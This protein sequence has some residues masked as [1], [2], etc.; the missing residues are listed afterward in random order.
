MLGYPTDTP[1]TPSLWLELIHPLDRVR[2]T[3]ELAAHRTGESPEFTSEYRIQHRNG[4]Y[5]WVLARGLAVRDAVGNAVRMAGSQ[6]DI[7]KGKIADPVTGLPNRLYFLDRVEAT[8][9]AV[10]DNRSACAVLFLDLDRF[11]LINDSL[12][13]SA[14]DELL[15]GVCRRLRSAVG[16][17]EPPAPGTERVVARFGGDEFAILLV[18]PDAE[19]LARVIAERILERLTPAFRVAARQVFASFSIGIAV[20]S[21]GQESAEDL[22]R[23]ADTA[24]YYAKTHGRG[25]F[26]IFDQQMRERAVTRL[27]TESELRKAI[28]GNELQLYYQPQVHLRTGKVVGHEALVR[29]NHPVRGLL[30]PGEFVPIAEESDLIIALGR[31]V[32]REACR[33]TAEWSRRF[34]A[35]PPIRVSVNVSPRQLAVGGFLEDVRF[36]LRQS[37]LDPSQLTLEVTESSIMTNREDVITLLNE[38][39]KLGIG[40][41]IDDFG[42]GYSSLSYLQHLPF[43]TVKIDR[44]F[45]RNLATRADSA[46]IVHA[47]LALAKSL[48]MA[49]VAEGVE[50]AEQLEKLDQ[51]ECGYAQGFYFARPLPAD[52]AESCIR[53]AANSGRSGFDRLLDQP[54]S[55]ADSLS[56]E[57]SASELALV[58]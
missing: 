27:E 24:M 54:S 34:H 52:V 40:L 57:N 13:H 19:Y 58:P 6:T 30:A 36:A 17:P 18:D 32:L 4:T 43:N 41:E 26:E 35:N 56:E 37:G 46:Q 15:I 39:K 23:N 2:V 45:I 42:T 3:A 16:T 49:V 21:S 8:L 5:I 7:T 29:W 28:P 55:P 38:L 33:Q 20:S 22:L 47:I 48:G 51:L 53:A 31:W 11:K 10:K 9:Q 1:P 44:S 25:R 12:G 14:G 50:N